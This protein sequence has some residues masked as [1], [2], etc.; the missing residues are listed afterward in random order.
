MIIKSLAAAALAALIALAAP[1]VAFAA[2]SHQATLTGAVVQVTLDAE[3]H[4]SGQQASVLIMRVGAKYS[5]PTTA[6]IVFANQYT[7]DQSGALLFS[8]TLPA[9][10]LDDY[11]LAVNVAGATDRY[12]ASLDPNGP[13][14][15]EPQQPGGGSSNPPGTDPGSQPNPSGSDG[16]LATTGAG[17]T[18]AVALLAAMALAGGVAGVLR[19]RAQAKR[20]DA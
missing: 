13:V 19:R 10:D 16:S 18:V 8:A 3:A 15:A 7:V 6:D 1:A 17:V 11:V 20:A 9:G 5:A 2:V 4:N 12:L 14:P